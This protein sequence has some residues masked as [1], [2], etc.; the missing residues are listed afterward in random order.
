M[1]ANRKKG[2]CRTLSY[3]TVQEKNNFLFFGLGELRNLLSTLSFHVRGEIRTHSFLSGVINFLLA[4]C[5]RELVEAAGLNGSRPDRK[6]YGG[7]LCQC[8]DFLGPPFRGTIMNYGLS[9]K[10]PVLPPPPPNPTSVFG[11]RPLDYARWY[12][13][14]HAWAEC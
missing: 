9:F 7:E 4:K 3:L 6:H 10:Y 13:Y 12:L 11:C 8:S 5:W 2:G 1:G 14:T